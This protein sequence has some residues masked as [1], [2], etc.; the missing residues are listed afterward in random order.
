[1]AQNLIQTLPPDLCNDINLF[2]LHKYNFNNCI[3]NLVEIYWTKWI[4][5]F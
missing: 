5:T 2:N 3:N 4:L 1:M